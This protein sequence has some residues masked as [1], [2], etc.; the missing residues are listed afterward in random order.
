[1]NFRPDVVPRISALEETLQGM[2]VA[3]E[4]RRIAPLSITFACE[5][6]R[7]LARVVV[8][9]L[10]ALGGGQN[11]HGGQNGRAGRNGRGGRN[12]HV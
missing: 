2:A 11:R 7:A 9:A 3:L 8:R 1:M 4:V 6:E 5:D 12:E 10:E